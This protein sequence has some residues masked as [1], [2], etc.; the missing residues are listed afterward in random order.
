MKQVF[1]ISRH[2]MFASGLESLLQQESGD[3]I[4]VVGQE[5]DLKQAIEKIEALQ[6]DVVILADNETW[7]DSLPAV[8][9]ILREK[10]VPKVIG[11]NLN[12]NNLFVY[13]ARQGIAKNVKDLI[14]AIE[15]NP[16]RE[17][18]SYADNRI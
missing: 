3:E 4:V 8:F 5:T 17:D 1:I 15:G 12:N 14:T 9:Y 18:Q 7:E 10:S 6:P 13:E 16:F 11:L 2:R